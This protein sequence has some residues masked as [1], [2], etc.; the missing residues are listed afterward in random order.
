LISAWYIAVFKII[1]NI[2]V[3][4]NIWELI[5]N[6]DLSFLIIFHILVLNCTSHIL[7]WKLSGICESRK[8]LNISRDEL[9]KKK[10]KLINY[11]LDNY[12]YLAAI[13]REAMILRYYELYDIY[14]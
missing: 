11:S 3:L 14:V 10:E 12:F 1:D 9:Y 2:S 5:T 8:M 7:V 4:Y 6:I 13:I